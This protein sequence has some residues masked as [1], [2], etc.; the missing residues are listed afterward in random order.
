MYSGWENV[1]SGVPQGS[2]L[3]PLLFLIYIN[4]LDAGINSKLVK[5]ADAT[6]LCRGVA[7]EEEVNM[8]KNDLCNIFQWSLV[9]QMQFNTEKCTV[10]H[11]GK[12]NKAAEYN[13]GVN[14]IKVSTQERDLGVIID[15]SGKSSEQ[16]V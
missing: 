15:K 6:K 12:N 7:T 16:C 11:I 13:L 5:F 2:V 8:L 9:W 1:I 14:K 3:G 4:D 10:L